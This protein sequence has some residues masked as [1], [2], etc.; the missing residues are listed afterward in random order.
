MRR[1]MVVMIYEKLNRLN[2]WLRNFGKRPE[3]DWAKNRRPIPAQAV[4]PLPGA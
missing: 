4:P 2:S 1:Q 3:A